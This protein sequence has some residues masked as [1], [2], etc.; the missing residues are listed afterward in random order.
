MHRSQS[1]LVGRDHELG[2]LERALLEVERGSARG[3]GL[4]GEPGIGK[5]RLLTELAER[6]EQR[7]HL[8]LAGR[9]AELERDLPF[10]LLID[11]FDRRLASDPPRRLDAEHLAQLAAVLPAVRGMPGVERASFDGRHH[12]A[13]GLRALLEL[14]AGPRP[15]TVLLDDVQWADAASAEVLALLL[16]R[17]PTSRVMLALATR[18]GRAPDLETALETAVRNGFAEVVDVGPLP[19]KAADRLLPSVR[20]AVRE[21]LYRESGGNPFYLESLAR[22]TEL[23]PDRR[24]ATGIAGVPRAVLAA[25][26]GELGDLTPDVREVLE[27]AAVAGDPF[28]PELAGAAIGA[29]EDAVLS[30]IDELQA[31]D[32]IRPTD[33]PRRF[34]FRHPLV[35]RAVYEGIPGGSR[36]AA[37]ARAA[38]ALAARGA[39]PAQRAHHVERAARPGDMD[40]VDVLAK[41]AAETTL[42]APTTAAGWYGGAVRLLPDG[43]EHAERR[44]ALLR[45]QAD[46]LTRANRAVDAR[47]ALR[48]AIALIPAD[49]LVL[50][51]E[52]T[53]AL[54]DL[55]VWIGNLDGARDMLMSTRAALGDDARREF[56]LLTLQLA[57]ERYSC[58]DFEAVEPLIDEARA[59]AQD[60][61]DPLLEAA[62]AV[63][64][65]A[66]A[67]ERLR[68][69]DKA[70]LDRA[71]SIL[72]EAEAL[73][74]ALSDEA[75]V[76]RLEI[77]LWLAT[78]QLYSDRP[79]EASTERG[80]RLARRSGQGFLATAFTSLLGYAAERCGRLDLAHSSAE[81]AVESALVSGNATI[82]WWGSQLATWVALAQGR[83]S[84]A[85]ANAELAV[86]ATRLQSPSARW[87]LADAQLASGDPH[88]ALE[89]LESSGWVDRELPPSDR[90][91]ALEMVVRVHLAVGRVEEAAEWAR[92]AR[93]EAGGR[94]T[95]VFGAI[96]GL[97]EAQVLLA[98]GQQEKAARV[99]L[100]GASAAEEAGAP[101]WEGR[102]RTVAGDALAA[103]G[104]VDEARAEL[105]RAGD[106]LH[107]RG[108][109]G[110]RDAALRVLRRLGERP[111]PA[112]TS[113]AEPG[114][115]LEV[116]TPRERDVAM[117]VAEGRTNR[118][119]GMQLH[120][121]EKTIEKHVSSAMA[122]LDVSSRTGIA[123]LVERER[124]E[125]GGRT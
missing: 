108:A 45:A 65:A 11:T 9:A 27:G 49:D 68:G 2:V 99:A 61:G 17:P 72:D 23:H 14:L 60:A 43:A 105:R 88:A 1:A 48:R 124:A 125:L 28:E 50:R 54:A 64:A 24:P 6:A 16:H 75:L 36:L 47:D 77:M 4:R 123:R 15:L 102:C 117:L 18:A 85:I 116:L 118:Q 92:Q 110:Y 82:M 10:A 62:A 89:T 104:K 80:L 46:A 90:L 52:T 33:V 7:G 107:A 106:D 8:V 42:S 109:A 81:E 32:L 122:K 57:A 3:I 38:D 56:A 113:A 40:A 66:A 83:A 79:A 71:Q 53:A 74:D 69:V 96:T 58:G 67:T 25:L 26:A 76:A 120:L 91:R 5:S 78:A 39:T 12:V 103:A 94:R 59:A 93:E 84:E 19:R 70:A 115:G 111:R 34:R 87:T 35:R 63:Q 31:T 21:H 51:V 22:A 119:I 97:I 30:A 86:E 41:A 13:R 37:H 121:S 55:E 114:G 112:P 95:G 20:R 29:S 98:Q 44:V 100:A 73:V 101:L